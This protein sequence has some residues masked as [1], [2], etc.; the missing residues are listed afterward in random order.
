[1]G[2]LGG[3]KKVSDP[4]GLKL[5]TNVNCHVGA[6]NSTPLGEKPVVLTTEPSLQPL[7]TVLN[8]RKT[9]KL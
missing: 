7:D 5:V 4:L 1:M 9:G 2:A 3:Q 6:G 8:K